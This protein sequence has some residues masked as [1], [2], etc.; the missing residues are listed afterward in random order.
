MRRPWGCLC[1]INDPRYDETRKGTKVTTGAPTALRAI[2]LGFNHEQPIG[3]MQTLTTSNA[4]IL[5][6]IHI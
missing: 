6:L 1:Y 5:S 2:H 4:Y 3:P